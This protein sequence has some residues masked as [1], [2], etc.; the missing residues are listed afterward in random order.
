MSRKGH[1]VAWVCLFIA[2]ICPGCARQSPEHQLV[3]AREGRIE[4]P[5]EGGGD[6]QARFYTYKH[7]G[8]NVNFFVRTD[9]EGAVRAHFDACYGC[10]KYKLGYVQEDN[11]V[12]CLACRLEY[13]LAV[14][15]WDYIGPCVPITLKCRFRD[16]KII[17]SQTTVE[18]GARFF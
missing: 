6:G 8:K 14:P 9:G 11:S 7:Q 4:I 18:R 17:I 12:V 10:F 13:D 16:H 3:S 15:V 1:R 5:W 2:V